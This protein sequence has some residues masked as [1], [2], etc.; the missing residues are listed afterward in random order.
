[1]S[2]SLTLLK[3]II[4]LFLI[5]LMGWIVVKVKLLKSTDSRVLSVVMVYIVTPC[6][7]INAFQIDASPQVQSGL[8]YS[9]VVAVLVHVV[10]LAV[11]A[12]LGKPLRMDVLEKASVIYTN[13][14]IL[15]IPIVKLLLGDE[16]VIYSCAFI[17]VQLVLI[18][19]H[20]IRLISGSQHFQ[21]KKIICNINIIAII[22]GLVIFLCGITLPG[23][24]QSAIDTTGSMIGPI[25]MMLAGMV[26]ADSPI[27]KIL[28]N[29]RNY[30]VVI[31]RLF[32]Y[33]LIILALLVLTH[34]ATF[35]PDGKNI[36]MTVFIAAIT[37]AC[38]TVTSLAQLNGK[39]AAHA[40]ELYV[41]TTIFSIISMPVILG[42]YD[43]FI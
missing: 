38:A 26:I 3:E 17:V 8:I 43:I 16:Y 2:V 36:L 12:L 6:V 39:G 33:P 1:M 28:K 34:A 24:V 22:V 31:L 5:M 11:T 4:Q 9:F 15:V 30:L 40:S 10:Y 29:A 20:C 23:V 35:I 19:T 7:I 14:G 18:W 13:A 25:G 27:L 37:P 42:L 21:I 41:L 32:V